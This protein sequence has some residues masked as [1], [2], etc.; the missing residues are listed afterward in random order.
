M[1]YPQPQQ[2]PVEKKPQARPKTF[3]FGTLVT[4][5]SIIKE[6]EEKE[7]LKRRK[8]EDAK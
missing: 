1:K 3:K 5:E 7:N 4:A 2:Q 8:I 6:L